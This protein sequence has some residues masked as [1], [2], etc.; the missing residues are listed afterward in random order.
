V[1][2]GPAKP[3]ELVQW[4]NSSADRGLGTRGAGGCS[5][6]RNKAGPEGPAFLSSGAPEHPFEDHV[7]CLEV[8]AK[9]EHLAEVLRRQMLRHFGIALKIA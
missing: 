6:K 3:D 5:L 8:I 1:R 2:H 7:D 4:T 9:V